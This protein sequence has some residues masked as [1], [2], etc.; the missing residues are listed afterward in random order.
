MFDVLTRLW[1]PVEVRA[2]VPGSPGDV[3]AVLADPT[4]YPDWLVGAQ[5]IRAVDADFPKPGSKFHHSVG[6]DEEATVDDDSRSV[7]ADPRH[8][9]VLEVH[10]GPL[11]GTVDFRLLPAPDGTEIRFRE[12]MAGPWKPFMPAVRPLLHAR[13][14]K[15]LE[16][17]AAVVAER[18][19]SAPGAKAD[20]RS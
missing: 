6:P 10:A 1:S 20:A 19:G 11:R 17:L 12:T 2:T 13:N 4:N 15:S 5:Q 3:W 16:Q 18:A 14:T 9:L 7:V 8:R